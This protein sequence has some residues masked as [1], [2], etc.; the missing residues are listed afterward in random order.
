MASGSSAL[1]PEMPFLP[2]LPWFNCS[3]MHVSHITLFLCHLVGA[4]SLPLATKKSTQQ[5][6]SH[7]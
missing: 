4:E 5:H 7:R 3:L 2:V 1:I 6:I